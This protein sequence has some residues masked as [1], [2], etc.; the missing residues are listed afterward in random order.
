[1]K[2]AMRSPGMTVVDLPE[3][4]GKSLLK[5]AVIVA[6]RARMREFYDARCVSGFR[7]IILR[8]KRDTRS[9]QRQRQA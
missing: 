5:R 6:D 8:R 7:K 4:P 1:M 3:Y 2:E 9:L